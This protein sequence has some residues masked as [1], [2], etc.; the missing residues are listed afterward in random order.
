MSA[1]PATHFLLVAYDAADG[2]RAEFRDQHLTRAKPYHE[3]GTLVVGG[4]MLSDDKSKMIGSTLILK[5]EGDF[6]TLEKV[7]HYIHTDPYFLNDVWDKNRIAVHPFYPGAGV[8]FG[9]Q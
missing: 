3:A 9:R 8:S 2:K 4:P 6:E 1:P 5:A 7:W